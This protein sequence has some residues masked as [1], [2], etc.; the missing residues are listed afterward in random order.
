MT[1]SS[2]QKEKEIDKVTFLQFCNL[3]GLISERL[4]KIMDPANTGM[5][6]EEAFLNNFT[7]IFMSDLTARMR[8]TFKM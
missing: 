7:S 5:I 8:L 2:N 4:L 6:T 1:V 3:P